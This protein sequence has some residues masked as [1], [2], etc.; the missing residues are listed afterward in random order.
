M[1][2]GIAT[3]TGP[4]TFGPKGTCTRAQIVTFLWNYCG[5]PE[6]VTTENPFTDVKPTSYYYKPVLWAFE[7]D[8]TTGTS[9]TTFGPKSTCTRAQVVTFLWKALT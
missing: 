6:P 1:E 8:V 4:T 5:S 3:G 2:N 7:N 9:P